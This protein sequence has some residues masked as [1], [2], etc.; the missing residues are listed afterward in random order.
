[1]TTLRFPLPLLRRLGACVLHRDALTG[2]RFLEHRRNAEDHDLSL[3]MGN[4]PGFDH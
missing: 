4:L 1:M 3:Q 2:I